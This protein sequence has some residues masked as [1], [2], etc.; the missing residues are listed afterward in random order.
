MARRLFLFLVAFVFVSSAAV[1]VQNVFA[2]EGDQTTKVD[3]A[4]AKA[5]E[6]RRSVEPIA[7]RLA[8]TTAF[9]DEFPESK[10]TAG[11]V[12]AVVYYFGK[13]GNMPGAVA[14]TEA[15]REKITDPSIARDVDK[16]MIVMYGEAGMMEKMLATADKL[17]TED[18]L[19]FADYWNIIGTGVKA[20]N[21]D[22]VRDY[23]DRAKPVANGD[24]FRADYPDEEF[25]EEE[26]KK[27]GDNRMGMILVNEGWAR[28]NQGEVEGALADFANADKLVRHS[29]L[30][31][32]EYDLNVYWGK[33]LMMKRDYGSAAE[34]L[35]PDALVMGNAD[36]LAGLRKSYAETNGGEDGFDSYAA[37]LH[38]SIATP[39]TA[40]ELA[41]YDGK[42]HRYSDLKAKVT[43][44][45]F[46][47]P[48]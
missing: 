9:L 37:D 34:R 39:M 2:Q 44:L 27:A 17:E 46:W 29:Y 24:A 31:I 41:D 21:W 42:R 18:A 48:T 13:L 40:F 4:Y 47:F 6:K 16:Q 36:A 25:T 7:E 3:D 26:V 12:G 1:G 38:K 43:L 33:T 5:M 11:A 45:A 28:A 15:L 14:Y 23:C 32:P 35:A 30:G 19:D 10:Y 22:L 20:E 8:I